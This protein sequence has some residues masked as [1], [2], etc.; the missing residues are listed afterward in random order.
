MKPALLPPI[1]GVTFYH[2]M[3]PIEVDPFL[4]FQAIT[5]GN[6]LQLTAGIS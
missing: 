3:V 1:V 5:A 4:A 6:G 2:Q